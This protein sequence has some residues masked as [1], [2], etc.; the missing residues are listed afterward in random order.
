MDAH[1][2]D[3]CPDSATLA[4]FAAGQLTDEELTRLSGHLERCPKCLQALQ[5]PDPFLQSLQRI[6]QSGVTSWSAG[7]T[8]TDADD[9]SRLYFFNIDND[10]PTK[11]PEEFFDALARSDLFDAD[12]MR[13]VRREWRAFR[14]ADLA[15][16][17]QSL[18]LQGQL[19]EFHARQ[20]LRGKTRGWILND[21][22]ILHPLGAGGMGWMFRA[23]HRRTNRFHALKV[24]PP[25]LARATP[26]SKV[27]RREMAAI[28]NL[29][30]PRL[31]A[32]TDAGEADG[33]SYLVMDEFPGHSLAEWVELNGPMRTLTA[34]DMIREAAEGIAPPMKSASFIATSIRATFGSRFSPARAA[35]PRRG[36]ASKCSTSAC[37]E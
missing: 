16:F 5:N 2:K 11:S 30:H 33:L 28:A 36:R 13:A 17:A 9:E 12:D 8:R 23:R 24:T 35:S 26:A 32:A 4:A 37:P 25:H 3:E 18:V 20:L 29:R 34:V 10:P 22:V 6:H 27:F 31:V 21:Y 14:T 1:I 19:T 15:A 7:P